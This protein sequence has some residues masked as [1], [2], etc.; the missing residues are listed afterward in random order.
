MIRIEFRDNRYRAHYARLNGEP[1]IPEP[2]QLR[3]T[4][5]IHPLRLFSGSCINTTDI[6]IEVRAAASAEPQWQ[7]ISANL[8][9]GLYQ[10]SYHNGIM[11]VTGEHLT[12]NKAVVKVDQRTTNAGIEFRVTVEPHLSLREGDIVAKI[13]KKSGGE[14]I[15]IPI[16]AHQHT[17]KFFIGRGTDCSIALGEQF[18]KLAKRE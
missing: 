1:A 15:E 2:E 13:M 16:L 4:L 6:T 14:S 18:E 17:A 10:Y 11:D 3:T 12:V 9:G 5:S 8:P 7:N